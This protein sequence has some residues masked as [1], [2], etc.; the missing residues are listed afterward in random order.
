MSNYSWNNVTDPE[1]AVSIG[2]WS[3]LAD[4]RQILCYRLATQAQTLN[5]LDPVQIQ[6]LISDS[7]SYWSKVTNNDEFVQTQV[8]TLINHLERE[9]TKI[10]GLKKLEDWAVLFERLIVPYVISVTE[11]FKV[12]PWFPEDSFLKVYYEEFNKPDAAARPTVPLFLTGETISRLHP[13]SGTYQ[14]LLP[15]ANSVEDAQIRFASGMR[16][17][18]SKL[19]GAFDHVLTQES[20]EIDLLVGNGAALMYA[21][22][23]TSGSPLGLICFSS[24][25]IGLYHELLLPP[26]VKKTLSEERFRHSIYICPAVLDENDQ[27]WVDAL[28]AGTSS[29]GTQADATNPAV[30]HI[31]LEG[32]EV[33]TVDLLICRTCER[34]DGNA[35]CVFADM[36]D[37]IYPMLGTFLSGLKQ[38]AARAELEPLKKY[39]ANLSHVLHTP[40]ATIA[41]SFLYHLKKLSPE[42]AELKAALEKL[43]ASLFVLFEITESTRRH[44]QLERQD[45][46]DLLDTSWQSQAEDQSTDLMEM[47][48]ELETIPIFEKLF[49]Q[50]IDL[51]KQFSGTQVPVS[52]YKGDWYIVLYT[53]LKNA[54]AGAFSAQREQ[55][56]PSSE[57]VTLNLLYPDDTTNTFTL[58][59]RNPSVALD[60]ALLIAMGRCLAGKL[61]RIPSDIYRKSSGGGFGVGLG[62][63]GDII[64]SNGFTATVEQDADSLEVIVKISNVPVS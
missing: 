14:D 22:R 64:S 7:S 15:P 24:P 28:E 30:S 26:Y 45:T 19:I 25:I 49:Q 35:R 13:S 60:K 50:G 6:R 59:I 56:V 32:T 33:G 39:A 31:A 9:R 17:L 36:D 11:D 37:W 5:T 3:L 4:L 58:E 40:I 2:A 44:F 61:S 41:T 62:I 23:D 27:A 20:Q 43:G 38:I 34:G 53:L 1:P 46:S 52:G 8:A 63:V 47:V 55:D 48:K 16:A 21:I 10:S 12:H 54:F 18:Q 57:P 42:E 51:S 29:S